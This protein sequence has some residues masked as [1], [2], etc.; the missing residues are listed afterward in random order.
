LSSDFIVIQL[1]RDTEYNLYNVLTCRE[2]TTHPPTLLPSRTLF[3]RRRWN[4]VLLRYD[5][6]MSPTFWWYCQWSV[7]RAKAY[8]W[9]IGYTARKVLI[10]RCQRLTSMYHSDE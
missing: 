1:F 10:N 3:F 6:C 5:Y 8:S 2:E 9:R 7:C 4:L